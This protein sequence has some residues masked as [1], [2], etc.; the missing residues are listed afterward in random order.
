[1][2]ALLEK[3]GLLLGTLVLL[4][5]FIGGFIV[6]IPLFIPLII[7][8]MINS[9]IEN[10]NYKAYLVTL[11]GTNFFC[12]NNRKG[13]EEFFKS[14]LLPHL[15]KNVKIVFLNG[16]SVESD[17]T[18]KYMSRALY[19]IKTK[20]GFPYLMK[21]SGGEIKCLSL[22]QSF[23]NVKNNGKDIQLFLRQVESF[24]EE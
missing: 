15:P 23:Y 17:Y 20:T 14:T 18:K 7:I 13:N 6:L 24:F 5:L 4:L 1:M 10:K 9:T 12:Y 19:S 11:E 8:S 22:N 3:G 16:R 2:I 21:V